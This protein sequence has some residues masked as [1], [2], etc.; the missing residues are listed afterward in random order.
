MSDQ[1]SQDPNQAGVNM[2]RFLGVEA[3]QLPKLAPKAIILMEPNQICWPIG[4]E[5]H[6]MNISIQRIGNT[7]LN[8]LVS[9]K[10]LLQL[11]RIIQ[12]H[13]GASL[14]VRLNIFIQFIREV[15]VNAL[16]HL[17]CQTWWYHIFGH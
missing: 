6:F 13:V 5:L 7:D 8:A 1:S 14:A 12:R 17:S 10:D 2:I 15:M 11:K 4:M 9:T 16:H 3:G